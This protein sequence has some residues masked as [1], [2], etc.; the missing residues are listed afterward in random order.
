MLVLKPGS[1]E[2][3]RGYNGPY[4]IEG[5]WPWLKHLRYPTLI[6]AGYGLASLVRLLCR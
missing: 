5:R 3:I 6:L 1:H 2:P 4:I